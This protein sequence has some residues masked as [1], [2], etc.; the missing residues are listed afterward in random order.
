MSPEPT[1]TVRRPGRPRDP[2]VD[3]RILAAATQLVLERGVDATT[4]DE[5]AA[6]ACVGKATVYRR[7][8]HKHE[9]A[10]SALDRMYESVVRFDDTGALIDDLTRLCHGVLRFASST[11]GSQFLRVTA[12]E[13]LRDP[14]MALV[15]RGSRA[16]LESRLA[17]SMDLARERGEI[18][19]TA[20]TS[21]AC[22]FV[23]GLLLSP[24]VSGHETPDVSEAP[25]LAAMVLHGLAGTC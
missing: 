11:V 10:G 24:V 9:L 13:S 12:A 7:W 3:E 23:V 5:V 21:W 16:R 20:P 2:G 18:P 4:I 25:A 19:P 1:A 8:A 6:R 22:R 17:T 15:H 14:R